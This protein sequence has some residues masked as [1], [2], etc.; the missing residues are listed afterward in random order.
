MQKILRNAYK[1]VLFTYFR[2]LGILPSYFEA[3]NL[4]Q[5]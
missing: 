4:V 1:I 3:V 5:K 2:Y